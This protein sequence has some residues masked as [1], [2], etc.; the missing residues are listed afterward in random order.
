MCTLV[1]MLTV[2][3]LKEKIRRVAKETKIS[4]SRL[5]QLANLHPNTLR[6]L[7]SDKWNPTGDTLEKTEAAIELLLKQKIASP[8]TKPEPHINHSNV[9][10][11]IP[12]NRLQH[13]AR[14]T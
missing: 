5:A 14:A 1:G 8:K 3:S 6:D 11:T 13:K 4:H 9:R 7:T 12:A 10:R 2:S